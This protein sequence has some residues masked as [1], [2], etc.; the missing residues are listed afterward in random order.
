[1]YV[2][3]STCITRVTAKSSS[4]RNESVTVINFYNGSEL[5]ATK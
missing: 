1:M 5:R 3:E 2:Q 4:A